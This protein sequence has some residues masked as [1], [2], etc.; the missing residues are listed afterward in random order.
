[1]REKL[2]SILIATLLSFQS[3]AQELEVKGGFIEDEMMLGQE[4]TFWMTASYPTSLEILLPD[5]NYNFTPF[6]FSRK[7][8]FET[9]IIDGKAFDSAVYFLQSYEIDAFQS[10]QLPA[11]GLHQKDSLAVSTPLDSLAFVE[12]AP[13]VT[14]TTTLL[15]DVKHLSVNRQFNYPLLYYILGGLAILLL[16]ATLI[17]GKR[18]LRYIKLRKLRKEYE[19]FSMRLTTY[20]RQ[21]KQEPQPNVAEE[22]LILWKNYQQR[23]DERPFAT[24]T[25]RDIL[26]LK[27]TKELEKPLK[28]IDRV[29]Y[30][31]KAEEN[32][33][34]DFQQIEDF[35][36]HR[37][38]KKVAEIQDGK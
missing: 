38:S 19:K 11:I 3:F 24:Y 37:Y 18:I 28:S 29:I 14:D 10:L 34:Q 36:Q 25:T 2:G 4:V 6:E 35:T 23:L 21:L 15:T 5:T 9:E 13:V 8:Y 16:I 1:M 27:F 7:Q 26:G 32:L 12:L 17:F 31:R 30:G 22:A 33:Y 20:I